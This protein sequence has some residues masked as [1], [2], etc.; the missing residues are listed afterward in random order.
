MMGD[1]N[2]YA[3][4]VRNVCQSQG[5]ASSGGWWSDWGCLFSVV[6]FMLFVAFQRYLDYR[7]EIERIRSGAKNNR[8]KD[9]QEAEQKEQG[10][11]EEGP[12][13]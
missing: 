3:D 7:I 9:A 5:A 11:D 12:E 4:S 8:D 13:G 6:A 10:K 2:V 1:L